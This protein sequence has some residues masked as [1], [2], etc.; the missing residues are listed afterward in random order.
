MNK[1]ING[2]N[3][4]DG[5]YFTHIQANK[6]KTTRI[7]FSAFI[8]LD[9]KSVSQNAALPGL[10]AHSCKKYP[11]IYELN[12]KLEELYGAGVYPSV[13]KIGD[14]QVL[15]LTAESINSRYATDGDNNLLKLSR[16]MCAMI[17]EPDVCNESFNQ[18]NVERERRE[19]IEEIQ[20]QVSDK[21]T[22]AKIMCEN[23]MCKNEKFG[24]NPLGTMESAKNINAKNVFEAWKHLLESAHIEITVVGSPSVDAIIKEFEQKF[25]NIVR[26]NIAQCTSQIIKKA[27]KITEKTTIM[28]VSQCKL[29]MGLRTA[30]SLRGST[31]PAVTVT[32][33]LLGGTPQSK[34]FVNV[35]EKMS[36]CYYCAS[37]YNKYKGIMLI[38]SGVEK[39]NLSKAKKQILLQIK[40]L[41]LGNFSDDELL[42]TKL[43]LI[44]ALQK[45]K[46]SPAS[47]SSWYVSQ[48]FFESKES[49][50]ESIE[51][52]DK[53]SREQVIAAAKNLTLD[54]I[55]VLCGKEE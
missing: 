18:K 42:K 26:K 28:D 8:P 48:A 13:G 1:S 46:D 54:T 36:L 52:F 30:S 11:T 53:V 12:K 44:Q 20:S 16:L 24:I 27:D 23:E 2:I 5:V 43:F 21:K 7:S 15:S 45:T 51:K 34:L 33:A 38:Q 14:M 35:R 49:V 6:F 3:I 9:E 37:S 25:Q 29:V 10:W 22:Y 4:K 39:Q 50:E 19:L 40:D 32:N 17:F 41:Q 31:V 47:L 55:Y